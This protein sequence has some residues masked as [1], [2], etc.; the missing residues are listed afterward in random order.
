MVFKGFY[1]FDF[2]E[3][4][5]DIDTALFKAVQRNQIAVYDIKSGVAHFIDRISSKYALVDRLREQGKIIHLSSGNI[6]EDTK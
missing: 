3:I 2:S 1:H 5:L 6:A 4:E